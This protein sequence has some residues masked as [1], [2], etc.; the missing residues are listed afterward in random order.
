MFSWS[1]NSMHFR[2]YLT[3]STTLNSK[4]Q[5]QLLRSVLFTN[6]LWSSRSQVETSHS[7][8]GLGDSGRGRGEMDWFNDSGRG[9]LDD[10]C[11]TCTLT[12]MDGGLLGCEERGRL[13]RLSCWKSELLSCGEI[14]EKLTQLA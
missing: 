4:L 13:Q 2:L 3:I 11:R 9:G 12:L 5:T 8:A 1:L 7:L 6:L 14:N 10:S